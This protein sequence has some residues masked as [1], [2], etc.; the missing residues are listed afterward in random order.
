MFKRG[1]GHMHPY[2]CVGIST[3]TDWIESIVWPSE[4]EKYMKTA[5]LSMEN[6]TET[7]DIIDSDIVTMKAEKEEKEPAATTTLPVTSTKTV[8]QTFEFKTYII[9]SLIV[10]ISM[11]TI[12]LSITFTLL[13]KYKSKYS[14]REPV[15][16]T[17][18]K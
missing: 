15:C 4:Y 8:S 7:I 6:C 16:E 17:P 2:I 3:F 13:L 18:L 12:I 14:Q 1:C 10:I 5:N 11:L 9:L